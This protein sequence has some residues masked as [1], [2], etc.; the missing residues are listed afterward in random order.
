MIRQLAALSLLALAPSLFAATGGVVVSAAG[1]P[2]AEVEVSAFQPESQEEQRARLI[3]RRERPALATAT[4]NKE[5]AFTLDLKSTGV[6][7]LIATRDGFAPARTITLAGDDVTLELVA[8][9]PTTGRV[10]ANG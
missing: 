4:T 8:A 9:K 1:D 6:V 3:Q 5:G 2:I 10:T 7:E